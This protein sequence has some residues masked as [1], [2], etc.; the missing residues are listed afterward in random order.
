VLERLAG[1]RPLKSSFQNGPTRPAFRRCLPNTASISA[2]TL[3]A[4]QGRHVD[5]SQCRSLVAG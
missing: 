4:S 1:R 5:V 3:F 2:T